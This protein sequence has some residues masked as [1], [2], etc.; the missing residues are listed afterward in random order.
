MPSDRAFRILDADYPPSLRE[1][2]SPPDPLWI[3]GEL[4]EG[5]SVA[6]VGTRNASEGALEFA[7]SLGRRLAEAGVAV[8]SGGALG[9]DSAAHEGA[10]EAGGATVVVMGTGLDHVYPRENAALF[11]AIVENG[12]A[13]VSPFEREQGAVRWTFLRRNPVLAVLTSALVLVEAPVKSG[14]RSATMAARRLGRPLFVVP[15]APWEPLGAGAF[16]ELSL[17]A[18]PLTSELDILVALG[19]APR[20]K[21]GAPLLPLPTAGPRV[22]RPRT[23]AKARA[24]V[25]QEE[26]ARSVELTLP[27]DLSEATLSVWNA[28]GSRALHA[29][30]LCATT[31]L[32]SAVVHEALLT[33]TLHAVLVEGPSG[34]FRRLNA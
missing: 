17:G 19:L 6:I 29:D 30:E 4:P 20:G 24:A 11:E 25:R 32:S 1:L 8:F 33:L 26:A 18:L 3:R 12:G 23:S 14:A 22:G 10:L 28:L 16:L 2:P 9:I 15:G 7:R 21:G 31:G 13:L 27:P 34:C 5:P